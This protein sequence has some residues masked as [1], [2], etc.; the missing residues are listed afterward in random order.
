MILAVENGERLPRPADCPNK[1]YDTML[2]CWAYDAELR[3]TFSEL[4][5]TFSSD[6]EYMNIRELIA[7]TNLS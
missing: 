5:E 3:P 2:R 6:T 4:L 1:V 7:E